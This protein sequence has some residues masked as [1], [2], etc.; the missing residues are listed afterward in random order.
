ML[1]ECAACAT[2]LTPPATPSWSSVR[3]LRFVGMCM[4]VLL[5]GSP[6]G[7]PVTRSAS[8]EDEIQSAVRARRSGSLHV[9]RICIRVAGYSNG[10]DLTQAIVYAT[11]GGSDFLI[12]LPKQALDDI[13]AS[14]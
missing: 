10:T 4:V 8:K 9:A 1:K 11:R 3:R 12:A 7:H 5:C 13:T 14:G 6:R 2:A